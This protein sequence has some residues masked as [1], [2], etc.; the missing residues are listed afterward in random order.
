MGKIPRLPLLSCEDTYIHKKKNSHDTFQVTI[1]NSERGK[2]CVKYIPLLDTTDTIGVL[3]TIGARNNS[4][5]LFLHAL[6]TL[7]T[8]ISIILL[9]VKNIRFFTHA[10]FIFLDE[11]KNYRHSRGDALADM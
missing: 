1:A 8:N 7:Q 4:C 11:E 3:F 9:Y 6:M 5:F 2:N 10:K